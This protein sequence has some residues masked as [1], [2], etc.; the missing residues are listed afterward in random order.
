MKFYYFNSTSTSTSDYNFS[1]FSIYESNVFKDALVDQIRR[2]VNFCRESE[3]IT[4]TTLIQFIKDTSTT[5]VY[6]ME[7]EE[8]TGVINFSIKKN[9]SGKKYVY[10]NALC[11][12][13]R[14][15]GL[16]LGK[17]LITKIILFSKEYNFDQIKLV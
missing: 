16:G 4:T 6:S 3:S 2:N 14:K 5:T 13:E 8:L 17:Q 11:V 9:I 10:I 15:S 7:N 1:L 12:S